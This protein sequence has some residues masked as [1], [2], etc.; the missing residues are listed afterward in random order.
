MKT[1]QNKEMDLLLRRLAVMSTLIRRVEG[2]G[3]TKIQKLLYFLQDAF[4]VALGY[5]F[6]MH[7]YGPFTNEIERDLSTLRALDCIDITPDTDGYG[8]HVSSRQEGDALFSEPNKEDQAKLTEVIE[9]L[10]GS[11]AKELE[12][13]ATVHFVRNLRHRSPKPEILEVVSGLKPKFSLDVI[14]SAYSFLVQRGLLES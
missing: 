13:L 7:H 1:E 11:D 8:F 2:S 3:K 6:R 10:G 9:V 14:E 5:K 12:L 4:G